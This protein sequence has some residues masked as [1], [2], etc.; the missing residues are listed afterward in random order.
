M[1]TTRFSGAEWA[2]E[3]RPILVIG[4][5]GISS[6][7]I[8]NLSRIG[9]ELYIVDPDTVDETNVTGGQMYRT[10][11]IG[12]SKVAAVTTLCR[13]MGCVNPITAFPEYYSKEHG[14]VDICITGL[15]NMKA[16]KLAFDLWEAH[17]EESD[18]KTEECLFIDGRL[19]MEMHEVFTIQGSDKTARENYR[20]ALFTDE[21]AMELDCSTKQSTFG[22]MGIA[23]LITATL[24]NWLTNRK[25]DLDFREVPFYQRTHYPMMQQKLEM[26]V[27]QESLE[28]KIV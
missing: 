1:R 23:S 27:Q 22:A 26:P 5:G 17:L 18:V 15:D 16:R 3:L 13:E 12:K 28:Q 6:W 7:T 4:A 24:C 14:M 20:K 10:Q 9:H 19:T 25:L 11:D 21:E 8:L 2:T